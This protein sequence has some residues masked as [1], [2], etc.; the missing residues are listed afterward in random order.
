MLFTYFI[1]NEF[2]VSNAMMMRTWSVTS[3]FRFDIFL[4][5]GR[6]SK[7]RTQW[8]FKLQS[9]PVNIGLDG[10]LQACLI[11]WEVN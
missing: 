5:T 11:S 9:G 2:Q 4:S 10:W 3:T 1:E 7:H 6:P 8:I